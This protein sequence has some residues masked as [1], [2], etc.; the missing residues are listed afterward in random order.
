MA[1][2]HEARLCYSDVL[3]LVLT[4]NTLASGTDPCVGQDRAALITVTLSWLHQWTSPRKSLAQFANGKRDNNRIKKYRVA[5]CE[6]DHRPIWAHARSEELSREL[7]GLRI[8]PRPWR[9]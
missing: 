3:E 1:G 6:S 4:K 7:A 5:R 2:N 9:V 8:D